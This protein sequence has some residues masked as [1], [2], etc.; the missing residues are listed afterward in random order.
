LLLLFYYFIIENTI[1][2]EISCSGA[3]H[4][5]PAR[6]DNRRRSRSGGRSSRTRGS[7]ARK[8]GSRPRSLYG[9]LRSVNR[10]RSRTN[11]A[12]TSAADGDNTGHSLLDLINS[13]MYTSLLYD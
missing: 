13:S 8:V 11:K 7:Q 12:A 10:R 6:R 4:R 2:I 9:S 1:T 5:V 3:Q